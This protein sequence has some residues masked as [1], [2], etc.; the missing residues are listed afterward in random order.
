MS[1]PAIEF[2][3]VN[4]S[5][6]D[7]SAIS[8]LS[9]EVPSQKI[10][11][12]LGPNGAGKT[13]AMRLI[14]GALKATGGNVKVMGKDPSGRETGES[15][16][17]QIGIVPAKPA[18][19][20][21]STGEDNLRYAASLYKVPKKDHSRVIFEAAQR[22]G[23]EHV[24]DRKAG[25]YSTG[26]KTRLVLARSILHDPEI[27]LYDEPTSGLDPESSKTVLELINEMTTQGK[28]V[29]MCTHLL[30]EAENLSEQIV[31]MYGG[32][33]HARGSKK[34][35]ISKYF[36]NSTVRISTVSASD[37]ILLSEKCAEQHI[38]VEEIKGN[39]VTFVIPSESFISRIVEKAVLEGVPIVG[40]YPF[41]PSLEDVY[42]AASKKISFSESEPRD[43]SETLKSKKAK[44]W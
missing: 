24:L 26:M 2:D 18:L 19:Y 12:L 43:V 23:I 25:E 42:F 30:A 1:S 32:S 10:T 9:F 21:R 38:S 34:E 6:G 16:R 39:D 37:A 22:F 29:L 44:R 11:V 5:F 7:V 28:T 27:L 40:V 20:E 31:M 8:N 35:L 17:E 13:T 41:F 15:I 36:K 4:F 33:V 3:C 14:T